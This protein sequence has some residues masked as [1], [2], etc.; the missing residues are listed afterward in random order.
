[1]LVLER[2]RR[3]E[4]KD[5]PRRPERSTGSGIRIIPSVC[6]GWFDL[7]VF[8]N[9][10]VVQG[11]GV[12]GGSLVYANISIDAKAGSFDKGWP[13]EITYDELAPYYARVG[14]ML[15]VQKVPHEQWPERTRLV[16]EAAREE[17]MGR[18]LRAARSGRH[19]RSRVALLDCRIR[20]TS[21]IRR[22]FTNAHGVQQG[23]CVH[24]GNCDIGCDVKAKN[25][26]DLNYLPLAEQHRRRD[27][28]AA[29]RAARRRRM[30]RPGLSSLVRSHRRNSARCRQRHGPDRR[31]RRRLARIDRAAAAVA[32]RGR[33]AAEPQRVPRP[34]LE[35]QRRLPDAG[36]ASAARSAGQSDARADDHGGDRLSRRRR[37]TATSS[38]SRTAASRTSRGMLLDRLAE[39]R[40]A[41]RRR[42]GALR[43]RAAADAASACSHQVMP[44]FAQG[45]DAANGVLS[46]K[47]GRLFLQ[48]DIQQSEKTIEAIVRTHEQLARA[49][50]GVPLVPLTWTLGRDLITPHPLGGANMGRTA[51]DGVVDHR[52]EVFGYRNL[53][54]ADGAI[55]PEAIGL[56]PSKTI[57]ALAER[58][59]RAHQSTRRI[60]RKSCRGNSNSYRAGSADSRHVRGGRGRRRHRSTAAGAAPSRCRDSSVSSRRRAEPWS[61]GR[62]GASRRRASRSA[63]P[64]RREARRAGPGWARGDE[65]GRDRPRRRHLRSG[66]ARARGDHP[67][68]R[69][70]R[71]P[72]SGGRLHGAAEALGRTSRTSATEIK[73][74]IRRVGRIEVVEQSELRVARHRLAGRQGHRHHQP[75]RRGRVLAPRR[76]TAPGPS[77]RRWRASLNL[78]A[79]LG[80]G[81]RR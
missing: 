17:R 39:P 80:L 55:V 56:N 60:G 32:R 72:D 73:E 79:E 51:A 68:G 5:Y 44:W 70:S 28:A 7:R 75:P 77:A 64:D 13:P 33:D 9:M 62:G 27:P 21:R 25:T 52:G 61:R 71:D 43:E 48:W 49:T 63:V 67:A 38:S 47:N 59:R 54:V 18:P 11:A 66:A 12:G 41:G 34:Q 46:L 3:W 36:A 57:A 58:D 24:L 4:A 30:P 16:K 19:L 10:S 20:T 53:F 74:V 6:N 22:T 1:M 15:D 69:T 78:R 50:G 8:P 42:A 29:P 31:A 81:S 23:T 45:R 37:S 65:E 26:L 40:S 2:G 35:Q 76:T 14:A